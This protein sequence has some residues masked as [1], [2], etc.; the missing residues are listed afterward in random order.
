MPRFGLSRLSLRVLV[1]VNMGASRTM[2]AGRF[3]GVSSNQ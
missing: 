1:G 2:E 3:N